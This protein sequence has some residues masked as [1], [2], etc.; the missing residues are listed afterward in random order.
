M[1]FLELSDFQSTGWQVNDAGVT[2]LVN[3]I[4]ASQEKVF[5]KYGITEDIHIVHLMAQLSH[6]SGEGTEMTESLNYKPAALLK[7]WPSHFTPAQAMA[8]GRTDEH[9]ADQKMIGEIAYGGRM[10]NAPAPSEDGYNYRGRGFIQTTGKSG[11]ADLAKLTG[12]DLVNSP[13]L[14]NDPDHAFECAVAEFVHYPNMLGYCESDDLLSVSS[15][16][17][18]GHRVSDPNAVVGYQDRA[19]QLKLWKHQ[20]GF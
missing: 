8:Y 17:N 18:V 16:I 12:L 1:K 5:A 14:V 2:A 6:E 11:Y 13:E 15:L 10:G 19:A 3:G 20:Y 4:L 9:P 7:V